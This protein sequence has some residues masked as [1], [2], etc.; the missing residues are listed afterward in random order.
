MVSE[1]MGLLTESRI[2]QVFSF[3]LLP[4]SGLWAW[5]QATRSQ[6]DFLP[7][8]GDLTLLVEPEQA[9]TRGADSRNLQKA[10]FWLQRPMTSLGK[11]WAG[12]VSTVHLV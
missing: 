7:G 12:H 3:R 9:E 10:G 5:P 4:E 1:V 11:A 8:G 2:S 6:T